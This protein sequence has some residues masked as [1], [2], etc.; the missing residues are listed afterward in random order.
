MAWAPQT[1]SGNV[2]TID[3]HF[4]QLPDVLTSKL[5]RC[6]LLLVV[7]SKLLAFVSR[8][9]YLSNGR[10]TGCCDAS[11]SGTAVFKTPRS[12][13]TANTIRTGFFVTH[14]TTVPLKEIEISYVVG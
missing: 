9:I 7:F 10:E 6:S 12:P 2:P 14:S 5:E 11:Q 1:G 13:C 4:A 3:A 8:P